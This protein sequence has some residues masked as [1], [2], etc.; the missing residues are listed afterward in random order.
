MIY[1]NIQIVKHTDEKDPD[2]DDSE[3]SDDANAG[4]IEKPEEGAVF[5]V[6]LTNSGSYEEA[7]ESERDLLTTDSDGFAASKM[8]PYG[9]YTVHQIEGEDGKAFVPD[10]TVYINED[11]HTYPIF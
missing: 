8:L 1:G 11:G 4:I 3:H 2:V 6:Y 9:R 10:F 7:K 5:E